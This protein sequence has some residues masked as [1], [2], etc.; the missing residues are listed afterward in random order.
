MQ[1]EACLRAGGD[2]A[3]DASLPKPE[4]RQCIAGVVAGVGARTTA[5]RL[6]APMRIGER[7]R[8]GG[9]PQTSSACVPSGGA[10]VEAHPAPAIE[11]E[12]G[13]S[14]QL[15]GGQSG[16]GVGLR[17][18][19]DGERQ[20]HPHIGCDRRIHARMFGA[21]NRHE[22]SQPQIDQGVGNRDCTWAPTATLTPGPG[23]VN[24]RR[25]VVIETL[26]LHTV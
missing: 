23:H 25:A 6:S 12:R 1:P 3:I 13:A 5:L 15:H 10:P 26:G 24:L 17:Q 22:L 7:R 20:T 2:S 9:E 8:C 4:R 16:V 19:R 14:G 21:G 11:P 18:R